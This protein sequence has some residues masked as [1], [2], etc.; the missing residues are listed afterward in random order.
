LIIICLICIGISILSCEYV[1]LLAPSSIEIELVLLGFVIR[2][3]VEFYQKY[4]TFVIR[5]FDI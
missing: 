1:N 2:R 5:V 4:A 3:Y